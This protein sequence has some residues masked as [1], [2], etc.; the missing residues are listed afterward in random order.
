MDYIQFGNGDKALIIIPGLGDGL[1][2]VKGSALAMSLMYKRFAK[3]YTVYAFSRINELPEE[4]STEEMADDIKD[5][6]DALGIEK[7]HI[8]GVPWAE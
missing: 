1:K 4:Y 8:L 7:A 3:D 2:T 5:A 6:M